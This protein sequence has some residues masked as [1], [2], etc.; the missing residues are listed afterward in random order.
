MLPNVAPTTG[1]TQP[2]PAPPAGTPPDTVARPALSAAALAGLRAEMLLRLVEALLSHMPRSDAP[3]AGGATGRDLLQTLI[4][5]LKSLPEAGSDKGRLLSDLLARLP[6]ELRPAA[7]KLIRT[8]LTSL[9]AQGLAEILRN[10]NTP[11]AQ[12]LATL[13]TAN[14]AAG[15]D[16]STSAAA[17]ERPRLTMQQLAAVNRQTTPQQAGQPAAQPLA[18]ARAL[19]TALKRLFDLDSAVRALPAAGRSLPAASAGALPAAQTRASPE[20]APDASPRLPSAAAKPESGVPVERAQPAIRQGG[21]AEDI[22]QTRTTPNERAPVK[23]DEARLATMTR[24]ATATVAQ[25]IAQRASP[26]VILQA[27]ARLLAGLSNEEAQV[28]RVLFDQ[29]LDKATDP[30]GRPAA[31]VAS[32]NGREREA[33]ARMAGK[34]PEAGEETTRAAQPPT[35]RKEPETTQAIP[36]RETVVRETPLPLPRDAT[37]AQALLAALPAPP[38]RDGIPLAFVPYLPAEE[39]LEWNEAAEDVP[40]EEQTDEEKGGE[41]DGDGA[42][43]DEPAADGSEEPEAPESADMQSRRQ[44]TADMVGVLEPG[45]VFYRKL[46][47][48]WT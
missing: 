25:A 33:A 10:P 38:L 16:E 2:S 31:L 9:S 8:V 35:A 19:Q 5:A 28:L 26:G 18:D 41:Q 47:D 40:P 46:G 15:R 34:M 20:A 7:E 43:G 39:D 48:Y 32:D 24:D 1:T 14:L 36:L 44:K 3:N 45:L 12:R 6:T 22:A 37:A 42:P 13:L 27:I 21:T 17:G 30:K 4:S 11:H 23:A 29:P